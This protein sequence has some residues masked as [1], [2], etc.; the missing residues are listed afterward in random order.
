M[1]R[2]PSEPR[3]RVIQTGQARSKHE[4]QAVLA[5]MLEH[6]GAMS[7]QGGLFDIAVCNGDGREY[8]HHI[9]I[10]DALDS[11][12]QAWAENDGALTVRAIAARYERDLHDQGLPGGNPH[13]IDV[14]IELRQESDEPI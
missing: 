1:E 2:E 5:N 4:L 6:A 14:T 12:R 3:Y 8:V 13:P 10:P 11:Y 9:S 7:E